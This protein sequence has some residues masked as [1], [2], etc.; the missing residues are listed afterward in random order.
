VR[1]EGWGEG[2]FRT[3][4]R[5]KLEIASYNNFGQPAFADRYDGFKN[6]WHGCED[7]NVP[8]ASNRPAFSGHEFIANCVVHAVGILTA[9]DSMTKDRSRQAKSAK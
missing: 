3:L 8:E 1:G 2:L 9:I 4:R 5:K 6:C 7:V